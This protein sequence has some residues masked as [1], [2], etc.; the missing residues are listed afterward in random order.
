[1]LASTVVQKSGLLAW[2]TFVVERHDAAEEWHCC[3]EN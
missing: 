1:M 3:E 2:F